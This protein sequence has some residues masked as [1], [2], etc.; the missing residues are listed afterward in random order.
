MFALCFF[1]ELVKRR[2]RHFCMYSPGRVGGWIE[3]SRAD[4]LTDATC[5]IRG[6][7]A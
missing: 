7:L 1:P 5:K 6:G 4:G 2:Y 3:L